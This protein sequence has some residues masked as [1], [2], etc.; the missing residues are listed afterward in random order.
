[1]VVASRLLSR[2][3]VVEMTR[4][5]NRSGQGRKRVGTDRGGLAPFTISLFADQDAR[6]KK[7]K[8]KSK[9]MRR[10]IDKL[11]ADME[12]SAGWLGDEKDA[13]ITALAAF[14]SALSADI[15]SEIAVTLMHRAQ[16]EMER[17]YEKWA[18]TSKLEG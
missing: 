2:G 15:D 6:L 17:T 8:N 9:L 5:K 13:D 14:H 18:G 11:F 1:M 16:D 7:M 12:A 4:P 10:V 3:M